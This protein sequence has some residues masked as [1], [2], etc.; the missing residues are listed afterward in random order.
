MKTTRT[1]G[2]RLAWL[3]V[4]EVDEFRP[5]PVPRIPAWIRRSLFGR[6]TYGVIYPDA[7]VGDPHQV[8]SGIL[9]NDSSRREAGHLT[10]PSSK[11]GYLMISRLRTFEHLVVSLLQLEHPGEVWS[12]VGGSGDGG[13]DGVGASQDGHVT[14]L[15]Q[16]K[17]QYWGEDPFPT[18]VVWK[19]GLQPIRKFLASLRYP[20]GV[21]PPNCMFLNRSR[22]T[23]WVA[24]Y[25][26]NLPQALSMRIGISPGG[27]SS[28]TSSS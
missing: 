2:M 7:I 18:K 19:A 23:E 26:S 4:W 24:K 15:L 11:K 1:T 13:V 27:I 28:T 3:S 12:H 8:M 10:Q 21:V 25:Y 22:I 14:G 5:I 16:C 17:W 9:E 6:S 20:D